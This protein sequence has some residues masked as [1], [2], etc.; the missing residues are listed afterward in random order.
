MK[1]AAEHEQEIRAEL[2]GKMDAVES[3]WHGQV[4]AD[5][6]APRLARLEAERE[7]QAA[8]VAALEATSDAAAVAVA[9]PG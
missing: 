6:L 9:A 2:A 8:A 4:L 7:L 1:T 3:C 5:V